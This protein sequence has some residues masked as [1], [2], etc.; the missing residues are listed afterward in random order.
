MKAIAKYASLAALAI[1]SVSSA[2]AAVYTFDFNGTDHSGTVGAPGNERISTA[3]NGS[4]SVSVR[5]TA[6]STVDSI[7][8]D[9]AY[10]GAFPGGYGVGDGKGDGHTVDNVDLVDFIV[11]QFDR[12]V[13]L[14]TA[15]FNAFSISGL[16]AADTD[17]TIG[18]YKTP[19]SWTTAIADPNVFYS[20]TQGVYNSDVA[21][22]SPLPR[23]ISSALYGNTWIIASALPDTDGQYDSFKISQ[24]SISAVPEPT[25]WAMMILGFGVV[26]ASMRR[27]AAKVSYAF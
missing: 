4:T 14:S 3:T 17:A 21:V 20:G 9:P 19:I 24:L 12:A 1:A 18:A 2:N 5:V 7:T 26:G 15:T 27:K 23:D 8:N 11:L 10:L 25:T 22:N 16:G 13:T 6:W